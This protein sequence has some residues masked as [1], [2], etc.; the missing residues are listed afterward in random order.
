MHRCLVKNVNNS[1][2]ISINNNIINNN[3]MNTTR[4]INDWDLRNK[5]SEFHDGDDGRRRFPRET[6]IDDIDTVIWKTKY[7]DFARFDKLFEAW[8][9]C[10]SSIGLVW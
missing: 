2:N 10:E 8:H 5:N 7:K 9:V 4:I 3:N 6:L 1:Q